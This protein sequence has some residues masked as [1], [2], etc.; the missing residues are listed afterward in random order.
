MIR[1]ANERLT[2]LILAAWGCQGWRHDD[3]RKEGIARLI[4]KARYNDDGRLTF[5]GGRYCDFDNR[6]S[7]VTKLV[8][9]RRSGMIEDEE[10]RLGLFRS[11]PFLTATVRA[12]L[13]RKLLENI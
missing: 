13:A 1:R 10:Y 5:A 12:D 8:D 2:G 4:A 9:D 6:A 3:D 7:A 11:L